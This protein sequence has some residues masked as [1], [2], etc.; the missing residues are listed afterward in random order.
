MMNGK[1][2]GGGGV[3]VRGAQGPPLAM[4]L[5][6]QCNN[7]QVHASNTTFNTIKPLAL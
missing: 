7:H 2:G 3:G 6:I 4:P 1:K 5:G